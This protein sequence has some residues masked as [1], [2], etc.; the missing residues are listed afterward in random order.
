M[1]WQGL[2]L[3]G[4]WNETI[5]LPALPPQTIGDPLSVFDSPV[6]SRTKYR[7]AAPPVVRSTGIGMQ[8]WLQP[9]GL[10][11]NVRDCLR[12][13]NGLCTRQMFSTMLKR[14]L[15]QILSTMFAVVSWWNACRRRARAFS[16]GVL[17]LGK[18]TSSLWIIFS[19]VLAHG[20]EAETQ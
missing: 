8:A 3:R 16:S 5:A 1:S 13:S 2:L 11:G 15:L 18:V 6:R 12:I 10:H 19:E 14:Y 17:R 4:S 20:G 9:L 7:G